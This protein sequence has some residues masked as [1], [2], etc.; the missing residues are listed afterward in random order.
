MKK[1]RA[2]V[3]AHMTGGCFRGS[4]HA[5]AGTPCEDA[6]CR[7]ETHDASAA[8]VCDGAGSARYAREGALCCAETAAAFAA[9]H[10]DL[11]FSADDSER[12]RM[13]LGTVRTAISQQAQ[14]LGA[15]PDDLSCTLMLTAFSSDG[16]ALLMHVGDGLIFGRSG[17]GKS[18][19]LSRYFH[20]YANLT[21]FVTSA[22][23]R[24]N[25]RRFSAGEITGFLSLTDGISDNYLLQRNGKARGTVEMLFCLASILPQEKMLPEYRAVAEHARRI[26][27]SGDD[28]SFA[29]L[30]CTGSAAETVSAMRPALR[31]R[32]FRIP[33]DRPRRPLRRDAALVQA[34]CTHGSLTAKQA[35]RIAH[36]KN[37]SAAAKRLVRMCGGGIIRQ[38]SGE[39]SFF[40]FGG[41]PKTE[42]P[43]YD[44]GAGQI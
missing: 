21:S 18:L 32:L 23:T 35:V 11:L 28:I 25:S 9:N 12:Q 4:S 17:K 33:A 10:F 40:I 34:I 44:F 31:N 22:E 37:E 38:K 41:S 39:K 19:L 15:V 7:A 16:R 24:C 2:H 27:N 3:F 43:Y 30:T 5:R 20:D 1:K 8:A 13:L 36:L 14:Q 29:A 6:V 26:C 42:E